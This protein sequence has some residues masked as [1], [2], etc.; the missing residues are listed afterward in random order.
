MR[1]LVCACVVRK[2]PKTGFLASRPISSFLFLSLSFF[3]SFFVSFILSH[4]I[5]FH[6]LICFRILHYKSLIISLVIIKPNTISKMDHTV[7]IMVL[8]TLMSPVQIAPEAVTLPKWRYDVVY[9]YTYTFKIL[10]QLETWHAIH[11]AHIIQEMT[12]ISSDI[13]FRAFH[14]LKS[15]CIVDTCFIFSK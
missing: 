13:V 2:P 12:H 5:P 1:R 14:L 3:L 15:Y 8:I 11:I 4:W 6:L 7:K 9:Y 10:R